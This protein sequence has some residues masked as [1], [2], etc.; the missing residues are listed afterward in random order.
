MKK[1]KQPKN[2]EKMPKHMHDFLIGMIELKAELIKEYPSEKAAMTALKKMLNSSD[3]SPKIRKELS[4][5][6]ILV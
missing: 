1:A 4:N 3:I 2:I 5:F 6:G